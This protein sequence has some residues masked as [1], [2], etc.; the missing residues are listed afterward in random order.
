VA[1]ALNNLANLYGDQG[2]YEEAEPLHERSLAIWEEAL[3]S[4]HPDVAISLN[5][6]A[7]LKV[8]TGHPR[9]ALP[10]MQRSLKIDNRMIDQVIQMVQQ[11]MEL[12]Q[13]HMESPG[14]DSA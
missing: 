10:L 7:L 14:S 6:L 4:D 2:R 3:G 12:H 13:Q 1:A 11:H 5:N 8:S 9:A